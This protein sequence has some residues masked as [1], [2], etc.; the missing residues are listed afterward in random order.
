MGDPIKVLVRSV[1]YGVVKNDDT[2][3]PVYPGHLSGYKNPVFPCITLN[4][5]GGTRPDQIAEDSRLHLSV[6]SK[7]GDEEL[8]N[9]YNQVREILNLKSIPGTLD[10]DFRSIL[11]MREIYINDNLFEQKTLTHQL[12]SRYHIDMI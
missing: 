6:W 3:V 11:L 2:I 9:I 7:T 12:A 10:S 8:W 4:R 5:R 1:L